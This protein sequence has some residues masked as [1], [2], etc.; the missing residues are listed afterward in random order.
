MKNKV[1]STFV[2]AAL[3][4]VGMTATSFAGQWSYDGNWYY[5]YDNGS[6]PAGGWEWI[7][8]DGNG[9][10]ECYFFV[11]Y[12]G[13]ILTDDWVD[14]CY[15]NHDGMWEENGVV[16]HK[17]LYEQQDVQT[18]TPVG[19]FY[20]NGQF[21]PTMPDMYPNAY[22]DSIEIGYDGA[23]GYSFCHVNGRHPGSG[24]LEYITPNTAVQYTQYYKD[25]PD[26]SG[27]IIFDGGDVIYLHIDG[28][29]NDYV[30]I[31]R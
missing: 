27:T 11:G 31:R 22:F 3:L 26:E 2:L 18:K 21:I 5:T 23:D 16:Q 4:A 30:Y 20:L 12:N 8:T 24:F 7:D 10:A 9:L 15:V 13:Y 28:D 29:Y 19:T 17:Y 14:G 25:Y 6:S 1:F